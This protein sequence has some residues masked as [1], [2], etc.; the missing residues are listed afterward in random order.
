MSKIFEALQ[1]LERESGKL[2]PGVLLEAQRVFSNGSA[3]VANGSAALANGSAMV[4]NGS[5]M[6][7]EAISRLELPDP[8]P[9]AESVKTFGPVEHSVGASVKEVQPAFDLEQVPVETVIITPESRIIYHTDPDSPGADRF[10]LLRM[11]L[12]PAN[13][14][15]KLKTLLVTSAQAQDGKS[16]VTLN[17]AT[18]L[19]EQGKRSVLVLEGDLHHPSIENRLGRPAQQRGLAECLEEQLSPLPFLR[20][21]DPL[22]WYLLPAGIAEGNPTELLQSPFL[23]NVLD[24]VR[25]YFDWV[26]VDTPPVMPLTDTLSL[27][28]L[29]DAC[30]MVMRA[31]QTPKEAVDGAIKRIGS[32]H[33]FALLLNGA[34]EVDRLYSGYRK[35][36]RGGPRKKQKTS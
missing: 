31:G 27:R 14:S 8:V 26:L 22:G 10:R 15:G 2:P 25:P 19:S 35:Y 4:A 20:R 28:P 9:N 24:T 18:A 6:A 23:A 7:D 30:L 17:L 33:I 1:R 29:V 12:W 11:Q 5:L 16:T 21:I 36:Y 34:E 32:Q 13:E 3:T